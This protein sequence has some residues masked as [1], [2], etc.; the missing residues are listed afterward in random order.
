[1]SQKRGHTTRWE[2][3]SSSWQ[4]TGPRFGP[5][6]L[7]VNP[8][9]GFNPER[10]SPRQTKIIQQWSQNEDKPAIGIIRS[11]TS[12]PDRGPNNEESHAYTIAQFVELNVIANSDLGLILENSN[13]AEETVARK[14]PEG[15]DRTVQ[16]LMEE[17]LDLLFRKRGRYRLAVSLRTLCVKKPNETRRDA[18]QG[19][20]ILR[21]AWVRQSGGETIQTLCTGPSS[22]A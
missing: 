13:L 7:T 2:G 14:P 15:E 18:E 5:I 22:R 8:V 17:A 21:L 16:S 4:V 12:C 9:L 20:K 1:M 11:H 3:G 6:Q 10:Q 19:R